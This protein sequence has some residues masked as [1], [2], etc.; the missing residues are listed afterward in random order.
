VNC[1]FD[2][3]ASQI[4]S[5]TSWFPVKNLQLDVEVMWSHFDLGL[6]GHGNLYNN[7]AATAFMPAGTYGLVNQNVISGAF[8]AQRAF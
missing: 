3:K 4:G 5:R 7:A 2:V 8:R 6:S 1:N